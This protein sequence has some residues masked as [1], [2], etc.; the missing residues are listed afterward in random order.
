MIFL[1]IMAMNYKRKNMTQCFII[2][3]IHLIMHATYPIE[4]VQYIF[5]F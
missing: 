4:E 2:I 3:Q 1:S 5:V